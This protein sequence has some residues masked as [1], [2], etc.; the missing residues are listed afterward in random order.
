MEPAKAV[1]FPRFKS[2]PFE[3]GE[4]GFLPRKHYSWNPKNWAIL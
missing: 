3:Q 4:C 1:I 2:V